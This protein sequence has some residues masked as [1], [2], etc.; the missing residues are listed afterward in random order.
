M[1]PVCPFLWKS[2]SQKPSRFRGGGFAPTPDLLTRGSDPGPRWGLRGSAPRSHYRLALG[3]R[4]GQGP[5]TF[6]SKFTPMTADECNFKLLMA[7]KLISYH[8]CMKLQRR[9]HLLGR[10]LH[11]HDRRKHFILNCYHS[12]ETFDSIHYSSQS[13]T[14]ASLSMQCNACHY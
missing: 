6:L 8:L 7:G 4:L 9:R 13:Q 12:S 10:K 5:S 3:A 2:D 1:R 14:M 11:L